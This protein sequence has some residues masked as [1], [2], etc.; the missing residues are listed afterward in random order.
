VSKG[1]Y[2]R[3]ITCNLAVGTE[4][5]S[6]APDNEDLQGHGKCE[7]S[8][9]A[10]RECDEEDPAES[11]VCTSDCQSRLFDVY[12]YPIE[13]N[14]TDLQ[15]SIDQ[16]IKRM[17]TSTTGIKS[18]FKL[19]RL[20]DNAQSA[21]SWNYPETSLGTRRIWKSRSYVAALRFRGFKEGSTYA[22]SCS[23]SDPC[24]LNIT[25]KYSL[26]GGGKTTVR[27]EYIVEEIKQLDLDGVAGNEYAVVLGT[28]QDSEA[29]CVPGLDSAILLSLGKT[30]SSVVVEYNLTT[31]EKG[32]WWAKVPINTYTS[33]SSDGFD[34]EFPTKY[35][36]EPPAE[37]PG[38][39]EPSG[40]NY[41]T[42]ESDCEG[43]FS[44]SGIQ[45]CFDDDADARH[46]C[47]SSFRKERDGFLEEP[48]F[49][50]FACTCTET[51][52]ATC[53]TTDPDPALACDSF[54]DEETCAADCCDWNCGGG[55]LERGACTEFKD[56]LDN[57]IVP[58]GS[59]WQSE[60]IELAGSQCHY[61]LRTGKCNE[62]CGADEEC[63]GLDPGTGSCGLD[64]RNLCG[65]KDE[66]AMEAFGATS[67]PFWRNVPIPKLLENRFKN[68]DLPDYTDEDIELELIYLKE[69]RNRCHTEFGET[70]ANC[71][72]DCCVVGGCKASYNPESRDGCEDVGS[73]TDTDGLI[74]ST[75]PDG[76]TDLA[77]RGTDVNNMCVET[78]VLHPKLESL[79]ACN[80]TLAGGGNCTVDCHLRQKRDALETR[81]LNSIAKEP[82][83]YAFE[84]EISVEEG[85]PSCGTGYI[86]VI[87]PYPV[88]CDDETPVYSGQGGSPGGGVEVGPC[89]LK[90]STIPT[91]QLTPVV[92]GKPEMLGQVSFK[93]TKDDIKY[94]MMNPSTGGWYRDTTDRKDA[95]YS[96]ISTSQGQPIL[97]PASTIA[98]S[99]KL[100]T[101]LTGYTE[102]GD[103]V[104]YTSPEKTITWNK[105]SSCLLGQYC[106]SLFVDFCTQEGNTGCDV[107]SFT[108]VEVDRGEL[109][110]RLFTSRDA[111]LCC[112]ELVVAPTGS[113]CTL[114]ETVSYSISK[115]EDY[116]Y[117]G[118][119]IFPGAC[120]R[121]IDGCAN[122]IASCCEDDKC[123]SR[124][125]G[126]N[127]PNSI[128]PTYT[129]NFLKSCT[130]YHLGITENGGAVLYNFDVNEFKASG[131]FINCGQGTCTVE[132][133]SSYNAYSEQSQVSENKGANSQFIIPSIEFETYGGSGSGVF[134]V[135]LSQSGKEDLHGANIFTIVDPRL[136]LLNEPCRTDEDCEADPACGSVLG[137][138]DSTATFCDP[139]TQ[140]CA[141]ICD[142][143]P[144]CSGIESSELCKSSCCNGPLNKNTGV[145]DPDC[146]PILDALGKK[147]D[148]WCRGKIPGEFGSLCV[149]EGNACL[150]SCGDGRCDNG[151]RNTIN[152]GENYTTCPAD[153][154]ARNELDNILPY[155]IDPNE[156]PVCVDQC[157]QLSSFTPQEKLDAQACIGESPGKGACDLRCLPK[158]PELKPV[159]FTLTGSKSYE[160]IC[161]EC[162][163]PSGCWAEED[164][165][166]ISG[167]LPYCS[168]YPIG[169]KLSE[170]VDCTEGCSLIING[171]SFE[172]D[173]EDIVCLEY[174]DFTFSSHKYSKE[175]VGGTEK[176]I[177]SYCTE[178]AI[179]RATDIPYTIVGKGEFG[180]STTV[181]VSLDE[182]PFNTVQL[183]SE[184]FSVESC[185]NDCLCRLDD[186][187][188]IDD[189]CELYKGNEMYCT[190]EICASL[191]G[192]GICGEGYEDSELCP[193]DCCTLNPVTGKL[194]LYNLTGQCSF[195]CGTP[196][197]SECIGQIA[198]TDVVEGADI[199]SCDFECDSNRDSIILRT[200]AQT[201]IS[202]TG[203]CDEE[204]ER[205]L[206]KTLDNSIYLVQGEDDMFL[207][208]SLSMK[209]DKTGKERDIDIDPN[210][211]ETTVLIRGKEY[212]PAQGQSNP[213]K[214][215]TEGG[216]YLKM[217]ENVTGQ[218]QFELRVSHPALI[219][220]S[221]QFPV[222][223]SQIQSASIDV[224]DAENGERK[225][226]FYR[227]EQGE[228]NCGLGTAWI[229]VTSNDQKT[230]QPL[231]GTAFCTYNERGTDRQINLN[232]GDWNQLDVSSFAVSLK[233]LECEVEVENYLATKAQA[234]FMVRGIIT[235]A[236]V[237]MPPELTPGNPIDLVVRRVIDER[238]DQLTSPT[239]KW[240]LSNYPEPGQIT[241]FCESQTCPQGLPSDSPTGD[242]TIVLQIRKPSPQIGELYDAFTQSYEVDIREA[243]K[244]SLGITPK[245]KIV[246]NSGGKPE[247]LI[248]VINQGNSP[249]DVLLKLDADASTMNWTDLPS[250]NKTINSG[251]RWD[252]TLIFDVPATDEGSYFFNVTAMEA[253]RGMERTIQGELKVV[254]PQIRQV[255][256]TSS[257]NLT[258]TIVSNTTKEIELV[259][260]ND[261]NID[262]TYDLSVQGSGAGIASLNVSEA[263][264][265]AGKL[266]VVKLKIDGRVGLH[267]FRV[268]SKSRVDSSVESCEEALVTVIQERVDL[269]VPESLVAVQGENFTINMQ[270]KGYG[271]ALM[272]LSGD[273]LMT[274]WLPWTQKQVDVPGLVRIDLKPERKG[275]YTLI[276]DL[277][278]SS[279]KTQTKEI[280][281]LV[282]PPEIEV[283]L[284]G[285]ISDMQ[286]LLSS[287]DRRMNQLR[288]QGVDAVLAESLVA[289]IE[290]KR[291]QIQDLIDKGD[292]E[293]AKVL[294]AELKNLVDQAE[295]YSKVSVRTGVRPTEV[296]IIPIILGLVAILAGGVGLYFFWMRPNFQK[297]AP[298]TTKRQH[299]LSQAQSRMAPVNRYK[300]RSTYPSVRRPG[301][302]R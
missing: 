236:T 203:T 103:K 58:L 233:T 74:D 217:S 9:G 93:I 247:F 134:N 184:E 10:S 44:P 109:D 213:I 244:Y 194:L 280:P 288:S 162:L 67:Y 205:I 272:L 254:I 98:G 76:V 86:Q 289:E 197:T 25:Y 214:G 88:F 277:V 71:P 90:F 87:L 260:S 130:P 234:Q 232:L 126:Y 278:L 181:D 43:I 201:C 259:V 120:Q 145:C 13:I 159:L 114:A 146:G 276:V 226:C 285:E 118:Y 16:T 56:D 101:R 160:D 296:N 299:P 129:P 99:T 298:P 179:C 149:E 261:G 157:L 283:Q 139:S 206:N 108:C 124:Y 170:D 208:F 24:T 136:C 125:Y 190:D 249:I 199:Y 183:P 131:K 73:D 60:N 31:Q 142:D 245:S 122:T 69:S 78:C 153:C 29:G 138:K 37:I 53:G 284:T 169:V 168:K 264:I 110:V 14:P 95:W 248:S 227:T 59:D 293:S 80:N 148:D 228:Q 224:F 295:E 119:E 167:P 161:R 172:I 262:D 246:S 49:C 135:T 104:T 186:S 116:V 239:F 26:E 82:A 12:Y 36:E 89:Y 1:A 79:G 55:S 237:E 279:G 263:S 51:A 274:S 202:T 152:L 173:D 19:Y 144:A 265:A 113:S 132:M 270:L 52:Q 8:C 251:R 196:S 257:Q 300:Y 292:Y 193:E 282:E 294:V 92:P 6:G 243:V 302:R 63:K 112:Q 241:Q 102:I 70:G 77:F 301:V 105:G 219:D 50:N 291:A 100:I 220:A 115:N 253:S 176:Q 66:I 271:K 250:A 107:Q 45:T 151:V 258:L 72:I 222:Y 42:S 212:E 150:N 207:R 23:S 28:C 106:R 189:D 267:E 175:N 21:T 216:W 163:D 252:Y 33:S 20:N 188:N 211:L 242:Q 218:Y 164:F 83:D 268:C 3:C 231:E 286:T 140:R 166:G 2:K 171:K 192:D 62:Y 223:L 81:L 64:C 287:V 32:S 127:P 200:Y 68:L 143:D 195:G 38:A 34:S 238:G 75:A 155:T 230:E 5:K 154:C 40:Y 297:T 191:C 17:E 209:D 198:G 187:C 65:V 18:T 94:R 281:I 210:E 255:S 47:D 158:E 137:G 15:S 225:N 111:A 275:N 156:M 27:S 256:L 185:T 273:S 141:C 96:V 4:D 35:L 84:E 97:F 165:Q 30:I 178:Y 22:P 39:S 229:R 121:G 240:F 41:C 290:K 133:E 85:I 48:S 54:E 221:I 147:P 269:L 177:D 7:Y 46:F 117:W 128:N 11:Y 123:N 91:G 204:N 215:M 174:S 180:G 182:P 266:N 57:S 61:S 235:N